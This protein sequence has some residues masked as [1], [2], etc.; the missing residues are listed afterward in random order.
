MFFLYQEAYVQNRLSEEDYALLKE[1]EKQQKKDAE[2]KD[3][4]KKGKK[5]AKSDAD[6]N[7]KKSKDILFERDGIEDRL[8]RLTPNSSR[9]GDYILSKDGE[10]LYYLT[11]FEGGRDLWKKDLRKDDVSLVK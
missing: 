11:S 6:D 8:V 4:A 1:V 10:T 9:L 7:A 2:K 3:D 5:D